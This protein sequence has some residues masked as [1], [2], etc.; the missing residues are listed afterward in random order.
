MVIFFKIETESHNSAFCD[1]ARS[2]GKM[3]SCARGRKQHLLAENIKSFSETLALF[4]I[5]NLFHN[6][7]QR[8]SI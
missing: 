8:L 6:D 5:F 7:D 1:T 2:V 3:S 4:P